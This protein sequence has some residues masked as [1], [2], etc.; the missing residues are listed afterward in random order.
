MPDA[1]MSATAPA[2]ARETEPD[3]AQR[4]APLQMPSSN[5]DIHPHTTPRRKH[6]Y[7]ETYPER[8]R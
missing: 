4:E 2:L 1:Y 3:R 8:L 6:R 5:P 7:S